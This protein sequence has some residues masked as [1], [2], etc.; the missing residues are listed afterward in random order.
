MN[1]KKPLF[2]YNKVIFVYL[3]LFYA[4]NCVSKW[5][6]PVWPQERNPVEHEWNIYGL[7]FKNDLL[8][9]RWTYKSHKIIIISLFDEKSGWLLCVGWCCCEDPGVHAFTV[10]PT[11]LPITQYHS[12]PPTPLSLCVCLSVCL[13]VCRCVCQCLCSTT[14]TCHCESGSL[15]LL[16]TVR[17]C[18]FE[19][20]YFCWYFTFG[21]LCNVCGRQLR[22]EVFTEEPT[23]SCT[24]SLNRTY[25]Q[26]WLQTLH[27]RRTRYACLV[28]LVKDV[29]CTLAVY[30]HFSRYTGGVSV[31]WLHVWVAVGTL[32]VCVCVYVSVSAV[33]PSVNVVR[34]FVHLL[35][36]GENDYAEEFGSYWHLVVAFF[37]VVCGQ[38][39][40]GVP[41]KN[42]PLR[43]IYYIHNFNRFCH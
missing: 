11:R 43:K 7:A 42:S 13:S 20:T 5:G 41:I 33:N 27:H 23:L 25:W 14:G 38:K 30:V 10:G 28:Y 4:L 22:D 2:A 15:L 32:A 3:L 18:L 40:Q 1:L 6:C 9:Q 34:K 24:H 8:H 12:S 29:D 16:A 17:L 26:Y 31:H 21:V 36:I 19:Q 35:D 39:L 37:V